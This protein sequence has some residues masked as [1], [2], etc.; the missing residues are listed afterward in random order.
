[1]ETKS[2]GILVKS[3]FF[4]LLTVLISTAHAKDSGKKVASNDNKA[5]TCAPLLPN[6]KQL[7]LPAPIPYGTV[8]P[9][10]Q[11]VHNDRYTTEIF[12]PAPIKN[13]CATSFCHLYA[14]SAEL[15][16]PAKIET[17]T[18]YVSAY[19]LF[20]SAVKAMYAG[21]I[22]F[23]SSLGATATASLSSIRKSGLIPKEAWTGSTTFNR[24][25][26]MSQLLDTLQAIIVRTVEARQVFKNLDEQVQVNIEAYEQIEATIHSFIGVLPKTFVYKGETYTPKSFAEKYFPEMSQPMIKILTGNSSPTHG[27]EKPDGLELVGSIDVLSK[28]AREILDLGQPVYLTYLHHEQYVDTK[29]GIMSID[30]FNYPAWASPTSP[31]ERNTFALWRGGHAVILTGYEIDPATDKVIKWKIQNSWGE[32]AGDDGDFHMYDDYF[33][34]Y[35]TGIAYLNDGRVP[36]PEHY[37][38]FEAR[39][40]A[41]VDQAE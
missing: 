26:K 2:G 18:E 37:R 21:N 30:A 1:M 28:T 9:E 32:K 15:E 40:A 10:F 16:N 19:Y 31:K 39:A 33:R 25:A 7:L 20:D 3:I 38:K 34:T 17:S 14:W 8:R 6:Y 13:Q 12:S 11:R 4:V 41:S 29:S 23:G 27:A 35:V 36:I 5:A 24:S 22:N